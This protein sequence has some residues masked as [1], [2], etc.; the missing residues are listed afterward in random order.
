MANF[1]V[2]TCREIR[3][4]CLYR[5]HSTASYWLFFL[6]SALDISRIQIKLKISGDLHKMVMRGD[7]E[8]LSSHRHVNFIAS[9]ESYPSEIYLK[10]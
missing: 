10:N 7:P 9:D 1:C 6:Y 2:N 3:I 8:L 4:K 5:Y